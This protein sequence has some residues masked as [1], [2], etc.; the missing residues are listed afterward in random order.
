MYMQITDDIPVNYPK[1][2]NLKDNYIQISLVPRLPRQYCIEESCLQGAK[3]GG[4]SSTD[5]FLL[6]TVPVKNNFFPVKTVI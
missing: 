4:Q 2:K 1:P 5:T 6:G 3:S